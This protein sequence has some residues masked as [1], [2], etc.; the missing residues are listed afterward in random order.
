M[1]R[2]KVAADGGAK[3]GVGMDSNRRG[4][5][6]LGALILLVLPTP[7]QGAVTST[8]DLDA[9]GWQVTQDGQSFTAAPWSDT[10]FAAN[11]PHGGH[12]FFTDAGDN[13]VQG[14]PHIGLFRGGTG[15]TGDLSGHY[16]GTLSFDLYSDATPPSE[17]DCFFPCPPVIIRIHSPDGTVEKDFGQALLQGQWTTHSVRLVGGPPGGGLVYPD[18]GGTPPSPAHLASILSDVSSV[19]ILAE[20]DW[21]D[22]GTTV[23]LDNATITDGAG[24]PEPESVN[25]SLTLDFARA[26]GGFSG[27]LFGAGYPACTADQKVTVFRKKRGRDPRVGFDL[28]E[29]SGD[30][31]VESAKKPGKYYAKAKQTRREYFTCMPATSDTL[32]LK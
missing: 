9:Q 11:P 20:V 23:R 3:Q 13:L 30:Y 8:F 14:P 10:S 32:Q 18:S 26:N 17:G 7:A 31:A 12:I 4:M 19:E 6:S 25:R 21:G 24:P 28:T 27:N 5:G 16:G 15:W 22:S 1:S 2:E 29:D